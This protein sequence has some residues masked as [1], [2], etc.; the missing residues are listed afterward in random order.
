MVR[1]DRAMI[2]DAVPAYFTDITSGHGSRPAGHSSREGTAFL[3]ALVSSMPSSQANSLA[4]AVIVSSNSPLLLLDGELTV[5]AASMS[6]CRAFEIDAISTPGRLLSKLGAGEWD[7]PQLDALL[8]ATGAG[9]ADVEAYDMDL[10][11][12]GQPTRQ[13]VLNAQ[14]LD[15]E[16]AGN[17]RM[18]LAVDD[19]TD[20]R[21]REKLKDDL[22]R[23]KAILLQELQHRVANSLQIIASVLLLSA[24]RVHSAETRGHLHNAHNRVMS[25]AAMQK[26]LAVSTLGEVQLRSYLVDLCRSIGASMIRDRNLL[27]IEVT[28][29]D[30]L[31]SADVSVSF[32]LI[33]TEL[34]INALK[35]AFPGRRKGKITVEY[36]ADGDNWTLTVG[37][38]GVGMPTDPE[39]VK[40][41]LGTSIVE[42]LA[43]QRGAE[44]QR[45]AGNPGTIVSIVYKSAV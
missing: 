20:A 15:Y 25:V 30:S 45:T 17:I 22:L 31:R 19:V 1:F 18:L 32:G 43:R 3:T 10:T 40:G 35:H 29:D 28:A 12:S 5:V 34:V 36:H 27:S 39:V 21:I 4:L 33:V 6:F 23:E 13:L 24:R 37:D 8:K 7:V 26:Q 42:A 14:K 41:G 9:Y 44:V 2:C 16:D 11:R 38:N